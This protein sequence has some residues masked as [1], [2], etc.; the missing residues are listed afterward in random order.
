M[1]VGHR[2]NGPLFTVTKFVLGS[3]ASAVLLNYANGEEK[4]SK[5]DISPEEFI[6]VWCTS[7]SLEEVANQTGKTPKSLSVR[8]SQYRRKGVALKKFTRG[9]GQ[10]RHDWNRLAALVDEMQESK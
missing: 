2:K 10:P 8:A 9:G 3:T 7:E 5:K 4:M 1:R 6:R